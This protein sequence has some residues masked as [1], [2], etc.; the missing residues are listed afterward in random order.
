M[1]KKY[2]VIALLLLM[3]G[4]YF[5]SPKKEQEPVQ[6]S[7]IHRLQTHI[8]SVRERLEPEHESVDLV[9]YDKMALSLQKAYEK[10]KLPEGDIHI[11]LEA[12]FLAG[13]TPEYFQIL[14]DIEGKIDTSSEVDREEIV[15]DLLSKGKVPMEQIKQSFGLDMMNKVE[16]IVSNDSPLPDQNPS[17]QEAIQ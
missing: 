1:K 11:I 12:A 6:P 3:G 8:A 4:F 5:F 14:K 17:K 2:I 9:A 15:S 7:S 13:S 10:R 16:E